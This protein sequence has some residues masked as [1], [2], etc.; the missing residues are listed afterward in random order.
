MS[1]S[2]QNVLKGI[3]YDRVIR[4]RR[5]NYAVL[6]KL[7]PS[8]NPFTVNDPFAPFAYPFY[9]PRGIELRKELAAKKIYVQTNWKYLLDKMPETSPEHVWSADILPL[10]VDQRY[11]P[12][13]MKYIAEVIKQ[14]G[15]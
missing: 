13:E 7:L 1:K 4:K 12:D 5:E 11:G 15:V 8:D 6:K 9:H 10:P 14:S 2:T 3:D